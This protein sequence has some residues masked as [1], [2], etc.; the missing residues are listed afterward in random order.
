MILGSF[1]II[2]LLSSMIRL[3]CF[4]ILVGKLIFLSELMRLQ[5]RYF[6]FSKSSLISFSLISL[7][8]LMLPYPSFL[9]SLLNLFSKNT[10]NMV[11]NTVL[12]SWLQKQWKLASFWHN[13]LNTSGMSNPKPLNRNYSFK[14]L[15]SLTSL[16]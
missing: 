15:K 8:F 9:K 4:V 12:N 5:S 10:L 7:Q 13:N 16:L 6:K 1:E 14:M 11:L 2:S 3:S